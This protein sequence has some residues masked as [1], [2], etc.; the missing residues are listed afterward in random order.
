MQPLVFNGTDL[1]WLNDLP[2]KELLFNPL[3][4]VAPFQREESENHEIY[5]LG[6]EFFSP[7]WGIKYIL[8]V[9]LFPFQIS[10][11]LAMLRHKFPLIVFS[12]GAGKSF[13]LAVFAIYYALMF[14]GSRIVIVSRTLR[15]AKFIFSEIKTI[16]NKSPIL[17]SL[18][19][20]QPTD[21]VD[22]SYYN[23]N[24]SSI[25]ALPLGQ[26]DKIRGQRSHLT[27]VD[28]FNS[29]PIEVFDIV[30]RGFSAAQADPFEKAKSLMLKSSENH[31][32]LNTMENILN[33]GNKIVLSGTA[34]YAGEPLHRIYKQYLK[35]L[36]NKVKGYAG[37]YSEILEDEFEDDIK[38]DYREYCIIKY[39]YREIP[40]GLLEVSMI[41]NAR[42][43][44]P[45][46]IF[47]MEYNAEFGDD[48]AGFF[49]A[50][51]IQMAT[52]KYPDGFS[53]TLKGIGSKHYIMGIDPARTTDRFAITIIE[54]GSPNKLVYVWSCVNVK[55][56]D[57]AQKIRELL[58]K[59][60]IAA[61]AMD[62]AGGGYPIEEL[63]QSEDIMEEGDKKIYR[64]DDDE[65]DEAKRGKKI[66]YMFNFTSTWIDEANALL[67]KNIESKTT[68]FPMAISK[69]SGE[70]TEDVL[71]EISE[72]KRE[73]TSIEITYT[74]TGKRHYDL[75]PA[76][77]RNIDQIV[78]HKDRYSAF[79]LAN[80]L[81]S[82]INKLNIDKNAGRL[83]KY[84]SSSTVGGWLE[85]FQ[86]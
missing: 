20:C 38:I 50:K 78:R 46:H 34:G 74:K 54:V 83:K 30:I 72:L 58:R 28:E 71:T 37:D 65:T 8:N 29:V 1:S 24:D 64:Y 33:L 10:T 18:S 82:C 61:I 25:V 15:Q 19:E 57:T 60:N 44:M 7:G 84:H 81:C 40:K 2:P 9:D 5:K 59:F 80:Y 36:Q 67:Q 42:V 49:K 53:V 56:R 11:I 6:N 63:L 35:I 55:Y 66:L 41:H 62:P 16:Y 86:Y 12:R 21:S 45:K 26:G 73:L 27:L 79:L 70:E 77:A 52:S 47:D 76:D 85:Q 4:D 22:R 32:A 51:D 23:I 3:T 17:R 43:T 14:P 75:M 68:M 69:D 39:P 48:S 31:Q 13:L